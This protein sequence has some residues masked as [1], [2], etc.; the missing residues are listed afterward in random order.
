MKINLARHYGMCFGVRDALRAVH[1]AAETGPVTV[2]GE[3]VHNRTV[4]EQLSGVGVL[5]GDLEQFDSATTSGVVITAHGASDERREAW[6]AQG[7]DVTDTT[8]PLV[9]KA[10]NALARLVV[11]GFFPVVIGKADHVEVRGLVG[12]FPQ[13]RVVSEIEE[14]AAL[15]DE[16]RIGVVSQTTQPIARVEAFVEALRRLRPDTDVRFIDTVCQPT[17]DR[18]SALEELCEDNEMVVVV[19]GLNSNNTK[20]LAR[21]VEQLGPRAI[22]VETAEDLRPE[23]FRKTKR[24]GV[25]AGTSTLDETVQGVVV[26]LRK[27][28]SAQPR[29]ASGLLKALVST[30]DENADT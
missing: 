28:A 20:Q 23:D 21:T 17:K 3:L 2:L 4:R 7:H 15:P 25:T 6:S 9:R 1:Q 11:E 29:G 5:K 12:D 16:P 22:H 26:R 14:L 27:I 8:C 10:H 18:Q 19:G 30:G 13:A 24:V